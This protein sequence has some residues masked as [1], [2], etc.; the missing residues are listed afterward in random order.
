M[1]AAPLDTV[2]RKY[3][4]G[5]FVSKFDLSY[6]PTP[7]ARY[8]AD[9]IS[10]EQSDK[11]AMHSMIQLNT[12]KGKTVTTMLTFDDIEAV[13][14]GTLGSLPLIGFYSVIVFFSL[15]SPRY[16]KN[17]IGKILESL[18]RINER[19]AN[20]GIVDDHFAKEAFEES[21][22]L[23]DGCDVQ[24]NAMKQAN[25]SELDY[26]VAK[27][28]EVMTS[29]IKCDLEVIASVDMHF[30]DSL[31]ELIDCLDRVSASRGQSSVPAHLANLLFEIERVKKSNS[32][33]RRDN[34]QPEECEPISES[35]HSPR[36]GSDL[37]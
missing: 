6:G 13:G 22:Q 17:K 7:I 18:D 35:H 34:E 36:L 3:V 28:V 23:L 11:L 27:M 32:H 4:K 29:S 16:V 26:I 5:V 9:F 15:D 24:S 12:T 19:L 8:P 2:R 21:V 20:C 37:F 31:S 10:K 30:V 14:I 1:S 25:P 33:L